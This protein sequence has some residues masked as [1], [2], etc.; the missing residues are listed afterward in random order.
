MTCHKLWPCI[1]YYLEEI[2]IVWKKVTP[3]KH[4]IESHN[5]C[6]IFFLREKMKVFLL[7]CDYIFGCGPLSLCSKYSVL[8]D[9]DSKKTECLRLQ[10]VRCRHTSVDVVCQHFSNYPTT[11][12]GDISAMFLIRSTKYTYSSFHVFCFWYSSSHW[13]EQ[14][15]YTL[16]GQNPGFTSVGCY[17]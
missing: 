9:L 13:C 1:I 8:C 5:S 10:Y 6:R 16:F 14:K 4:V 15:N 12:G 11:P 2:F 3:D 17:W 7:R